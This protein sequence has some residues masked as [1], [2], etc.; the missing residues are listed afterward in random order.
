MYQRKT[1]LLTFLFMS[2]FTVYQ[3]FITANIVQFHKYVNNFSLL[4]S[5]EAS[6]QV[7]QDLILELIDLEN[8]SVFQTSNL[9]VKGRTSSRADVF[10]N[11]NELKA[12]N[13]G[14]FT[15]NINLDEG[16]NMLFLVANDNNGNYVE[17]EIKVILETAISP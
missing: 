6:Q 4:K 9:K 12:D 2:Y 3:H 14:N 15:T 1:V 13:Q 5:V 16:E 7:G 11:Q 8:G 10:V 17:K